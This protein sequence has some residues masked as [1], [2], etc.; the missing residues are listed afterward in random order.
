M[1]LR[2]IEDAVPPAMIGFSFHI[3]LING[4]CAVVKSLAEK[5]GI[6]DV[7]L[8]GGCMQNKIILLE[9]LIKRRGE[10]G[11]VVYAGESV[12][13]NDGG[14]SLGQLVI[15]GARHVSG[16]TNGGR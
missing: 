14:L 10:T 2:D 3:W 4:V 9:G 5:T 12:P 16:H 6:K 15:G 11:L 13:A 1:V 7:A 8:G